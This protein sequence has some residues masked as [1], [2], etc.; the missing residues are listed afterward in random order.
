MACQ[1]TY[2]IY[3]S[4]ASLGPGEKVKFA[5]FNK[6]YKEL[7]VKTDTNKKLKLSALKAP[8]VI[9][10]FWASWC[11]PCLDKFPK[12]VQLKK[13]YSDDEVMVIGINGDHINQNKMIKK[14]K[15]KFSLN[16]PLV[17]DNGNLI[18][19]FSVSKLPTAMLFENGKFKGYLDN[20]NL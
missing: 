17:A 14:M 13:K 20:F 11:V 18:N 4:N 12:L 8:I 16:F 3:N 5:Q 10:N 1:I 15:D 6:L 2:D 7:E 19:I 9:L